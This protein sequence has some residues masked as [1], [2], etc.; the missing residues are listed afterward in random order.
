M[1]SRIPKVA[2]L[3]SSG[4]VGSNLHNLLFKTYDTYGFSSKECDLLESDSVNKKLSFL[5]KN[6]ILIVCSSIT[7]LYENSLN[8]MNKN[9]KMVENLA[10]FISK[11]KIRQL[12]FLS[13]ID[14]YGISIDGK[15]NENSA[16]NPTDYYATSK[17]ASEFI[18]KQVCKENEINLFI[19]RLSGTFGSGDKNKSTIYSLVSNAIQTKKIVLYNKGEDY[20]DFVDVSY[21][22][23]IIENAIKK[24]YSGILNIATGD[25]FQIKEIAVL[26]K[27]IL[28]NNAQ[29]I[30]R[31]SSSE[32]RAKHIEFDI[33]NLIESHLSGNKL[34]LQEYLRQY[35]MEYNGN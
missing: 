1:K 26:I 12:I 4:F 31:D 5:D 17:V 30:Y 23:N 9:I 35:I 6:D 29:I 18:L 34:L 32:S 21:V 13:T 33:K 19:P 15:C 10:N 22:S 28:N 7:R 16:L 3:G 24:D 8:S 20:R 25:S 2:I 14:V 27:D 11:N